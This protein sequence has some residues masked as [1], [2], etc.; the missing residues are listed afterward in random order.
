MGRRRGNPASPRRDDGL[1]AEKFVGLAVDLR[2]F[3][4]C[5]VADVELLGGASPGIAGVTGVR[6]GI[7]SLV[8]QAEGRVGQGVALGCR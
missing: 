6:H 2:F 1:L 5:E 4:R 7:A 8:R 3:G